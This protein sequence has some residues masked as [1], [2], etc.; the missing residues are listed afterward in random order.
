MTYPTSNI[1]N[2][3]THDEMP[4]AY[5]GEVDY[6]VIVKSGYFI[7]CDIKI[8]ADDITEIDI[9]TVLFSKS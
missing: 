2:R 1:D 9:K 6:T 3:V 4:L 8:M 7:A 5:A